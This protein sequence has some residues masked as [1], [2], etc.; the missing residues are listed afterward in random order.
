MGLESN[1]FGNTSEFYEPQYKADKGYGGED[2]Y[3]RINE[4]YKRTVGKFMQ[5]TD[6][7][8]GRADLFSYDYVFVGPDGAEHEVHTDVACRNGN[9]YV[10][11]YS[12]SRMMCIPGPDALE[13]T[14][15]YLTALY[16]DM[17][18]LNFK[19]VKI[20]AS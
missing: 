19:N 10:E 20:S 3:N 15:N 13:R 5:N 7:E 17:G 6:D 16:K 9:V 4:I 18:Y 14:K 12:G 2:V 8:V 1:V 11:D